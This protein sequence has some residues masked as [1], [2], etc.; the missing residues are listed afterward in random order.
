MTNTRNREEI[1]RK[2]IKLFNKNVKGKE[3]DT[4][5]SNSGHDG[6]E[7]HWLETQMGI[8]HNG[9]NAPD[10]DGFE[11][12]NHT[13]SKTT[14]GDWSPNIA[15]FKG[16]D[17][18]IT[19]DEF[20][21][22][23]GAPNL[24]KEG[25]FSWSGKP[26][27]KL[28]K[29]N[30]FGQKLKIDSSNN[31]LAIYSFKEDTRKN[32]KSIVPKKFQIDDLILARWD[33]DKMKIKVERKFNNLGWFKCN[34][35]PNGAYTTITFGNPINFEIWIEGVKKGLIFFDSG[36]YQGN[37]RPYSQWRA[38]NNYWDSLVVETH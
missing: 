7:G 6:K 25:R 19:R 15:I 16:K 32:K 34:K 2:I 8:T 9:N 5:S 24:E 17:K 4:S 37:V 1:K 21:S 35:D 3:S 36:M 23:F 22:I 11:M 28:G 33:A 10:I 27:P 12:K 31:I 14:F 26:C 18:I 20:L 30:D 13:T 29:F 38:N